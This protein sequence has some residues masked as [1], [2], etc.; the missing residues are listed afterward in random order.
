MSTLRGMSITTVATSKTPWTPTEH[1]SAGLIA[2]RDNDVGVRGVAPRA[3]IYAYDLLTSGVWADEAGRA[4]AMAHERAVT[5]IYNNSWVSGQSAIPKTTSAA[6]E[7]AIREGVESGFGGKG[8]FY[9]WGAGN[10]YKNGDNTN[11]DELR[12]YFAVTTV[13]GIGYNDRRAFYS[14]V[15]ASL[16]VCAPSGDGTGGTRHMTTTDP[17]NRYTDKFA[18]TSAAAPIVSG[19][20]ALIRAENTS[21]TWRDVKLILA[22]SARKNHATDSGWEHGAVKYGPTTDRYSFSH[23]YGFGAV[24]AGAAVALARTWTNLPPMREAE[25]A[26]STVNLRIPDAV[27]GSAPTPVSSTVTFDSYIEFVE[28]VELNTDWDHAFIRT[29]RSN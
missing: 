26:S 17:G 2:A 1:E 27:E 21:L 15:G 20:A 13:C 11:L 7:L 28:F 4:E 22:N 12:N 3:T 5:A 16:W 6:V 9:V 23:W 18:G 29:S 8:A 19:V 14:V 24:D 10:G 25:V